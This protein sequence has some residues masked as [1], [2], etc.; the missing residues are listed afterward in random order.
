[1]GQQL[2]C[3]Y[4]NSA[5]STS[6]LGLVSRLLKLIKTGADLSSYKQQQLFSCC[7]LATVLVLLALQISKC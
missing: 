5:S 1:M 7:R 3:L 4:L 6:L 2:S